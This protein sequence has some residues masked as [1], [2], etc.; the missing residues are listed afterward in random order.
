MIEH[1]ND[2][3]LLCGK[4]RATGQAAE[5]FEEGVEAIAEEEKTE[6]NSTHVTRVRARPSS[7]TDSMP[8][9]KKKLKKDYLVEA[10]G[11]IVTSFQD[12]LASKKKNERNQ[13]VLRYVRS[14]MI[15]RLTSHELFKAV[16]K[17]MNRDVE[18][19]NY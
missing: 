7:S 15:S 10:V 6:V 8:N 13:V 12:L 18:E 1:W 16:R 4:D 5:T 9:K 17:L 14:S 19:L 3:V 11:V 2:I